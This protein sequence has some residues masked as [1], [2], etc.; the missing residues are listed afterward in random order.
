MTPERWRQITQIFHAALL[1][2]GAG[3]EAFVAS[4]CGS[5]TRLRREVAA[6]LAASEDAD[7]SGTRRCSRPSGRAM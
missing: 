6:M 1:R 7:G 4:Q 3:R 5:D 2:E